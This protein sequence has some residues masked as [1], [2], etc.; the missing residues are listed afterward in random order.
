MLRVLPSL[1]HRKSHSISFKTALRTTNQ[2]IVESNFVT[3][4]TN[5]LTNVLAL[6]NV[7]ADKNTNTE[8]GISNTE[9]G[10]KDENESTAIM[11]SQKKR[12]YILA[13]TKSKANFETS[14]P[15]QHL[16]PFYQRILSEYQTNSHC[17]ILGFPYV[18]ARSY[19]KWIYVRTPKGLCMMLRFR[20][21]GCRKDFVWTSQKYWKYVPPTR[22]NAFHKLFRRFQE[23]KKSNKSAEES[24]H[25]LLQHKYDYFPDAEINS[26]RKVICNSPKMRG[27]NEMLKDLSTQKSQGN[28]PTVSLKPSTMYAYL[29]RIRCTPALHY[30]RAL[31]AIVRTC[32]RDIFPAS[33]DALLQTLEDPL[34]ENRCGK[35]TLT[36][37][38]LNST[39]NSTKKNL[40]KEVP[41]I[42]L[43][44]LSRK[45]AFFHVKF[46]HFTP[47]F[48]RDIA[49]WLIK[50]NDTKHPPD[51][52]NMPYGLTYSSLAKSGKDEVHR[53]FIR[54]RN[55]ALETLYCIK[56][57]NLENKA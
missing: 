5:L 10:E 37:K 24:L 2:R 31:R 50:N 18:H 47:E 3:G 28:G 25:E 15:P 20:M 8:G 19:R 4:R 54:E 1:F 22:R 40:V 55:F 43:P 7:K 14:P 27:T 56:L 46:S 51:E 11:K 29:S 53:S 42:P 32:Y 26:M 33:Y 52:K 35:G 38:S 21:T 36:T 13:T 49:V 34:M 41:K 39:S 9:T 17:R 12:L 48:V 30:G 44:N 23:L 45:H 16:N 57:Q 6:W